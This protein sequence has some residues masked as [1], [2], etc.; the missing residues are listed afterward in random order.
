MHFQRATQ[1]RYSSLR[2]A[3]L[4]LCL[5]ITPLSRR[6]QSPNYEPIKASLII[7]ADQPKG[8]ISP[9]IY[10]QFAEHLGRLIYGGL[11]GGEDSSIPNTRGLRNDVIAALKELHIPVIR[12]PGGC[13]ADEYHWRDG[14]GA[15]DKRP[16]RP[17]ASWGGVD[18]NAFGTHEFIDLCEMHSELKPIS[19]AISVRG[20]R[21]R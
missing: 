4:T 20:R 15:R 1:K 14:I 10:G 17:N 19:T 9:H 12:W 11:W 18:T 3:A 13:F 21:W 2:F 16:K 8:T 7:R 6:A 5:L